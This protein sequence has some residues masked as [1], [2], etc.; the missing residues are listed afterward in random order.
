[1]DNLLLQ[2][3]SELKKFSKFFLELN[4]RVWGWSN[5]FWLVLVIFLWFFRSFSVI[6]DH[7]HS[8]FVK[9][10]SLSKNPSTYWHYF[11]KFKWN[12]GFKWLLG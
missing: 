7:F 10:L 12:P 8:L 1:L 5:E 11:S 9:A 4:P 6:F 3:N 2:A